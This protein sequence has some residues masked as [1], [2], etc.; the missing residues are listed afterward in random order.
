MTPLSHCLLS[1][2]SFLPSPPSPSSPQGAC[3]GMVGYFP[4]TYV[5]TVS[6]GNQIY[7]SQFDFTAEGPGE[8]PLLEGQ[9]RGKRGERRER[10]KGDI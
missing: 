1:L 7:M 4:A 5:Q 10:W 8:L 9:V 3:R 6:A 2:P